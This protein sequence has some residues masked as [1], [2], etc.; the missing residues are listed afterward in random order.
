MIKL[1]FYQF[2]TRK[3]TSLQKFRKN[4]NLNLPHRHRARIEM[5]GLVQKCT[6]RKSHYWVQFVSQ[7]K[8]NENLE[9]YLLNHHNELPHL[10]RIQNQ[11]NYDNRNLADGELPFD[12]RNCFCEWLV[13]RYAFQSKS[14]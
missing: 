1:Y 8:P 11:R 10:K 4:A 5:N 9:N 6:F 2:S 7:H 12:K 14:P 3:P 13:V